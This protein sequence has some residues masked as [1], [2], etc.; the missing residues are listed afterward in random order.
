MAFDRTDPF[1]TRPGILARQP[2][3]V[4]FYVFHCLIGFLLAAILTAAILIADFGGIG[5]LVATVEGGW[6]AGLVF[7]VLNGIVF[8][9]VQ[10][11]IAVMSMGDG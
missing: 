9:G 7:F 5:H 4:R 6:L 3:L 11:G 1:R 8:A 10:T 2:R